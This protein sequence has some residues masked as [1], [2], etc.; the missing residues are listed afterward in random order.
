[1]GGERAWL[2]ASKNVIF[3]DESREQ[4]HR[5]NAS[6]SFLSP[7]PAPPPA[8]AGGPH[9]WAQDR[10]LPAARGPRPPTALQ[11]PGDKP[12]HPGPSTHLPPNTSAPDRCSPPRKGHPWPEASLCQEALQGS[13]QP[14]G[15]DRK[16]A[17]PC[18]PQGRGCV[19][20]RA[21]LTSTSTPSVPLFPLAS[22][23]HLKA[24]VSAL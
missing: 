5:S 6:H 11:R 19:L 15:V 23:G 18:L 14:Q 20:F 2:I 13:P 22:W 24:T 3:K 8:W 12:G 7:H 17:C 9:T 16:V 21:S 10:G 1:M 4:R